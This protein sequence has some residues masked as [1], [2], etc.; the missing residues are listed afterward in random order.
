MTKEQS[1]FLTLNSYDFIKW[2]LVA[3]LSATLTGL[4]NLL[5]TWSAIWKE[6]L[7]ATWMAWITAGIGY[8]LK[9]IFT[10]NKKNDWTN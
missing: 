5:S 6:Q 8:L 2:F 9:N 10:D 7:I 4:Y 3:C 1:K